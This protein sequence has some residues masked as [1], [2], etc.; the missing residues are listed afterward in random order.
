M[1][2]VLEMSFYDDVHREAMS[3]PERIDIE[4]EGHGRHNARPERLRWLRNG[5]ALDPRDADEDDAQS[6]DYD[7]PYYAENEDSVK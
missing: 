4:D 3:D 5:F 1:G 2:C 7:P 6:D